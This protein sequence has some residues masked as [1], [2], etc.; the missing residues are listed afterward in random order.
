[1]KF[2]TCEYFRFNL[3]NKYQP[4]ITNCK[5]CE[6]YQSVEEFKV[7]MGDVRD[8]MINYLTETIKENVMECRKEL[9]NC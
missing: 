5:N 6:V 8:K 4:D 1:M 2:V 7:C 9:E 3:Y